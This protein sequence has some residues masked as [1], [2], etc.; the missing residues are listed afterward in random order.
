[1]TH[2]MQARLGDS[3]L[4]PNVS[5]DAYLNFAAVSPPSLR[6]QQAVRRMLDAYAAQGVGAVLGVIEE[7]EDL[8]VLLAR[9]IGADPADIGFVPNTSAGV[10][11]I[12][13][14]LPWTPGDRVVCFRGEFPTNVTPWQ[15]AAAAH[16]LELIF[17]D[18]SSM[19]PSQGDGLMWLEDQLRRGVRL[20]AISAV[21]FQTGLR[22]PLK[23]I[24]EL[25]AQYGAELFVDA[26]QAVGVT[27][28]DVRSLGIDYL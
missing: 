19:A 28:L 17:G 7:R 14:C 8:R 13:L 26:I 11:A 10:S 20:V 4:F 25:C 16:D 5:A 3:S 18:A 21:Q 15:R 9:L 24:G 12:A 2:S 1:M 23:A 6:V 22:M 27:P